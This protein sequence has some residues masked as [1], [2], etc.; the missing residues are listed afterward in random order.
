VDTR[1]RAVRRALTERE[2]LDAALALLDAGRP[3]AASI[4][5][6]AAAV[7][8]PPNAVYTY[9]PDQ[10]AIEY[11]LIERLLGEVDRRA[12]SRSH[13]EDRAAE[14]RAAEGRA[15][16]GRAAE[17]RAAEDRAAEDWASG[18]R[19]DLEALA[20]ELRDRLVAHP[21]V[22]PLLVGRPPGGPNAFLLGERLLALLAAAGFAAA[23]AAR[24]AYLL[25]VY[26]LG[27]LVV[28]TRDVPAGGGLPPEPERIAAR[29]QRLDAVPAERFPRTAAVAGVMAAGVGADQFVWGLRR[30][31]DGLATADAE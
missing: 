26:V 10:A 27:A 16:E 22:V 21:G 18:W 7:G 28:E 12:P 13:G 11:A 17:D 19:G 3:E 15:A 5:R 1:R 25:T 23:T 14:G 31:V 4:R 24:G 6:I 30:I 2:I 9:F 8:V 29:R 20:L